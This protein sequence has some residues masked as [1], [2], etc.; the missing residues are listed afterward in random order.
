MM[1]ILKTD[2]LVLPDDIVADII[3]TMSE[4]DFSIPTVRTQY[5]SFKVLFMTDEQVRQNKDTIEK[6]DMLNSQWNEKQDIFKQ[7]KKQKNERY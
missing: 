6:M 2:K 1:N 5:V 3:G 4:L 7:L